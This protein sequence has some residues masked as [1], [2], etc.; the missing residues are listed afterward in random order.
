LIAFGPL[1][2]V[3][4]RGPYNPCDVQMNN[5]STIRHKGAK[6]EKEKVTSRE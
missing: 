4:H 5:E 3:W 6:G 2:L 1:P